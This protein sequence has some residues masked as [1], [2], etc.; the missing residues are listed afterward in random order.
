MTQWLSFRNRV[1]NASAVVFRRD[2]ALQCISSVTQMRYAGDW[3]FW[4]MMTQYGHVAEVRQ[5]L[6]F[7]RMHTQK[8]TAES[9]HRTNA[10]LQELNSVYAFLLHSSIYS[11]RQQSILKGHLIYRI[12]RAP[13]QCYRDKKNSLR[14]CGK[15]FQLNILQGISAL[16]RFFLCKLGIQPQGLNYRF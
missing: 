9:S 5:E 2:Y 14:Q 3:L 16:A 13:N 12:L 11:P 6:N 15:L 1:Y 7:F 10:W 4:A 8:V